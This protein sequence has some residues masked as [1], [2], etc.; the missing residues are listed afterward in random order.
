V[1]HDEPAAQLIQPERR[2]NGHAKRN[3]DQ[4]THCLAPA[5]AIWTCPD[6][7][8]D[9]SIIQDRAYDELPARLPRRGGEVCG[10]CDRLAGL[11]SL[12]AREA[13]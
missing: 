13:G 10:G 2:G 11:D 4:E 6:N 5:A 3:D 8:C 7:S 1:D 12:P 9:R